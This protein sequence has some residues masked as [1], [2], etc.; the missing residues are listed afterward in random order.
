MTST[1]SWA[2][3]GQPS[4]PLWPPAPS[5][6]VAWGPSL[7][8][9]DQPASPLPE[10]SAVGAPA[11]QVPSTV[12]VAA[13]LVQS[14]IVVRGGPVTKPLSEQATVGRGGI[15]SGPVG[16][17]TEE[18]SDIIVMACALTADELT[19]AVMAWKE[20]HPGI[21][22][23]ELLVEV[24]LGKVTYPEPSISK[25]MHPCIDCG[26]PIDMGH[27]CDRC[28]QANGRLIAEQQGDVLQEAL[29]MAEG[30]RE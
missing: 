18:R 28:V 15:F 7:A 27:R 14:I 10:R 22:G 1:S 25:A 5:P 6:A 19:D 23:E 30:L 24:P 8:G 4:A 3:L 11:L 2:D 13:I 29:L 12:W 16:T 26:T 20:Y 17:Q 21:T 9:S